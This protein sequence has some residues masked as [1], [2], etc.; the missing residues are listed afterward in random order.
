M[1]SVIR[2]YL[3]E[4]TVIYG[5]L[6]LA[7]RLRELASKLERLGCSHF[8]NTKHG[9]KL[10]TGNK[11]IFLM[12]F[13]KVVAVL[14]IYL[15]RY[16]FCRNLGRN[17]LFLCSFYTTVSCKEMNKNKEKSNDN[18]FHEPVAAFVFMSHIG[19]LHSSL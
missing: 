16:V 9:S 10:S 5:F 19:L 1:L 13:I 17:L 2:L 8:F 15:S 4:A 6:P 18:R 12:S 14:E 3:K 7:A 11:L